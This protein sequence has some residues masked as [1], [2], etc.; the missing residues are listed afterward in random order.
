MEKNQRKL[1]RYRRYKWYSLAIPFMVLIGA[2]F[3]MFDTPSSALTTVPTKTNFQGRLTNS[4]GN[5]MADG[6]YNMKFRLFT[7]SSGGTDV[8][9]ELR[10]TTNR[11]QVTNGLFSVRL[12]DVTAI[13]A[14][15]FASGALYF[16]VELPTPGTA[17]C[18]TAGCASFTEGPMTPRNQLATSAYSYNSETLDGIDSSSFVQ[19]ARGVQTDATAGTSSIFINKTAS[20]NLL[21]LQSSGT[22]AFTVNNTGTVTT[23]TWQGSTVAVQYGG[24]GLTSYTTGDLVYASGATT[25]G[26]LAAVAAGSC[27]TSQGV[28]TAPAWADCE[29]DTLASVTARGAT[30][31]T[32]LTFNGT[33]S[34][35]SDVTLTLAG[36]ENLAVTSDLSGVTNVFALTGTPSATAGTTRGINIDQADSVNANGL[37]FG[38]RINNLDTDLPM[39]AAIQIANTG[40]GG[41][42]NVISAPSFLL[43]GTGTITSGTWNGTALTDAFVSNTLTA[44]ILV[45][46]GSTTD[47]VDLGTAEVAGTLAAGSG[48][49]GQAS[50][51]I[52]DLLYASGAT[53]LSKLASV[54]AGSCLTSQGTS[55]APAWAA[56]EDDTLASV[57]ARGAT[58]STNLTFNGTLTTTSDVTH[59]LAGTENLAVNSDLA[60]AVN[61]LQVTGT[62]S[63][64]AG[65][66]RGL[67]VQQADSVNTN[68]LDTGVYINNAD[69]DLAITNAIHINNSGGGGYT[70]LINA[71]SLF[72]VNG[73]GAI[74]TGT[75]QGSTVGVQYGGTGATTFTT[76]GLLYGSGTG[77]VQATAA[78]SSSQC[79]IGGAAPTWGT[80]SLQ[81]AY[82]TST[83]GTTPEIKL[84]ST[85]GGL[86]IQDANTTINGDLL[87]VRTGNASGLG[88][89]MFTVGNSGAVLSQNSSDSATAFTISRSGAGGTLF[90]A[91][92][93]NS[94]I[95]IG[96][97]TTDAAQVTLQL[98]SFSTFADSGTCNATTNQGALYY[99]TNT[100]AIRTC[101]DSGWRDV[102][103]NGE[104]GLLLYGVIPES[105][106]KT[107]DLVGVDATISSA[108]PC[109][110][111]LGSAANTIRWTDCT[112]YAN[113]RKQVI[114][115][116]STNFNTG[117]S[118]TANAFQNL[119]I[120]TAGSAPSFG[121]SSTTETSASVPAWS[122]STP[123]ICLATIKENAGGNGIVALY[124]TRVF[125][126]SNKQYA[127]LATA[128]ANGW[129][130]KLNGTKG[131]YAPT[132]AT[133]NA[134]AGVVAI[135]NGTTATTT[136]NGIIVIGGPAYVKATA[137][138]VGQII[139]PTATA[140]FSN[141]GA[142]PAAQSC[143]ITSTC[144]IPAP[145]TYLGLA[146]SAFSNTCTANGTSDDCRTSLFTNL[147]IR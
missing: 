9:N 59:T 129:A 38:L 109:K 64:T 40:G 93:S 100:N 88:T 18:S 113:G 37:D 134:F 31:S 136:I 123:P 114:A 142:I 147:A 8:W 63:T 27:L 5:I 110:V 11:V 78:G 130:V 126:T 55:T 23:G 35:T 82:N 36:T 140:G 96:N 135:S 28:S 104:L 17:T 73:S 145:F 125:T 115:A 92:T 61:L 43:D 58:T 133:T 146:Q 108:G 103:T 121:T 1:G 77:A 68:G 42:T 80:C 89:A 117:I 116:Q 6:Q 91:D 99:S 47:A 74:T 107:G 87:T 2:S 20:G 144:T 71:P 122:V 85:R 94:Q 13:P 86:D 118:T 29:D 45:G 52:G 54:A 57:T 34:A 131:Q 26:K 53:T 4:A 111:Y 124:D 102:V 97:S 60:G 46:S 48:G 51:T 69:T 81:T 105:G 106:P 22:D 66:T 62:P 79:L 14:S 120:F 90:V 3:C 72:I 112:V 83:G 101:E 138:T 76:G 7:V 119:C 128:S 15:L 19:L 39:T 16:E 32:N 56:C 70:N 21:Q 41:Y 50:Y 33:L 25:L 44:S 141:T 143:G 10:E 132:N 67:F 127:T 12:G 30:T 84:D 24:T 137:G 98:D 49:T 75:W 65:T 95:E 139:L